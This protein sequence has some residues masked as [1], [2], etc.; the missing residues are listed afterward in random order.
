MSTGTPSRPGT[1]ESAT[2]VV[3][4]AYDNAT[5]PSGSSQTVGPGIEEDT[6]PLDSPSRSDFRL[7]AISC[8]S[9]VDLIPPRPDSGHHHRGE[10]KESPFRWNY[11]SL[12]DL[13]LDQQEID[14]RDT[15]SKDKKPAMRMWEGW[16]VIICCSWLN[17]LL[18][19]MPVSWVLGSVL[20][21]HHKLVFILC[22]LSM[23]P[24]VKLHDLS[25][26]ELAIR[27]GGTKTGLLNASMSN[28]VELVIAVTALRKC[29]LRVVQSSLIGSMLSKLLLILGMCFFAGGLRFSEQGFDQTATQTH[30][31]LLSI[32]E[33]SAA[34]QR[35]A[36]LKMSHGVS[37]VFLFIY[38][39]YLLF[40][41][42]SHPHLYKD[43]EQKSHKLSVKIPINPR[44]ISERRIFSG[45]TLKMSKSESDSI[46]LRSPSNLGSKMGTLL[47]VSSRQSSLHSPSEATLTTSSLDTQVNA[48][49]TIDPHPTIRL[50]TQALKPN[51]I[52]ASPE[53]SGLS[54]PKSRL[55]SEEDVSTI[56]EEIHRSLPESTSTVTLMPSGQGSTIPAE[57]LKEP[58]LSLTL[59]L[60]LLTAVTILATFNAEELVESM[61]GIDMSISKQ[62]IGL[63]LLPA[64]SS[65]A[66][67][68]TAMNVSVKDQLGL[69]VSVA[70]GSAIQITLLIIPFMV[71]LGWALNKPLTLL[72]D[73]FESIVLYISVQT[74]SHV[75]ADGKSNWLDGA[76]LISLYVI[77][78][79]SFWYYPGQPSHVVSC[80]ISVAIDS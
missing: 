54:L 44:F 11:P 69:S 28:T 31:S 43:T 24:L 59:T 56:T 4:R 76:I 77:I 2:L 68:V 14:S 1:P 61:D 30:S 22:I 72:F 42:W 10:F 23:I 51:G 9:A 35:K 64:V 21:R 7:S 67:C 80:A 62:W 71:I 26:R 57:S 58:R 65:V 29:E 33:S 46:R 55:R 60:L 17:V 38:V 3:L 79:V 41:F 50:V 32:S 70:V 53:I 6:R 75:V 40:Q 48:E 66:E 13:P 52:D 45:E 16:K 39:F 34:E 37:I 15:A 25:T 36:I 78:A 73:P 5:N 20:G 18:L 19:L 47:G 63:I 74:M 12:P 8:S 27:F 49:M